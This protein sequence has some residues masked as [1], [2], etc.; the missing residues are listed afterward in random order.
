MQHDFNDQ[1]VMSTTHQGHF[2]ASL[3]TAT[4]EACFNLSQSLLRC[5]RF[6]VNTGVRYPVQS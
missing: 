2:I 5:R 4:L 3:W 6:P 1:N